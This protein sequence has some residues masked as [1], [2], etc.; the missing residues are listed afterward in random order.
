LKRHRKIHDKAPVH[1]CNICGKKFNRLDYL[2]KHKK[3]HEKR[4]VEREFKCNTC[5]EVFR[6]AASL[7]AHINSVH[8]L[9]PPPAP[10]TT[11]EETRKRPQNDHQGKLNIK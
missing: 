7:K 5:G 11:T 2:K 10:S 6:N 1:K 4:A 3:V 9:P 8:P